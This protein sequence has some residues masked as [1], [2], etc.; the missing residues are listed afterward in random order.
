MF[1]RKEI[2]QAK[3]VLKLDKDFKR[4]LEKYQMI[5]KLLE[6]LPGLDCGACGSPTC[7][8]LAEDIVRGRAEEIDCPFMLRDRL[9]SLSKEI[10]ALA[11]RV[12]QTMAKRGGVKNLD[13]SE[14]NH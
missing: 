13:E 11:S 6:K 7:R 3:E 12:P 8:A 14:S 5:E 9:L 2:Y 1:K 10:H 4:A